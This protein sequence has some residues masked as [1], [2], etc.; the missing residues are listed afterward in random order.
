MLMGLETTRRFL[1]LALAGLASAS[2]QVTDQDLRELARTGQVEA[3]RS[4]LVKTPQDLDASDAEGDTALMHAVAE[5]HDEIVAMLLEAGAD[6]DRQNQQGETALHLAARHG[7]TESARLLLRAGADFETQD[8]EARSPLY[9][10]VESRRADI[11]EMLQAAALARGKGALSR[12]AMESPDGTLPPRILEST[13]AP[14]PE[15][16][17]ARGVEGTVVLMVLVRRD[18]SV[19][20]A[21][22]SRGLED[23]LDESA[24]RTVK[25]WKFLPAIRN[26]KTVEVVLEVEVDFHASGRSES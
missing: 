9:R 15:S 1:V 23:S 10:A 20:A 25:E 26:G 21:S 22:V 24:L 18:G 11:I 13:P 16:A 19:G 17:R 14:Y 2:P 4:L 12:A 6:P 7:R 8:S 5:K 3:V